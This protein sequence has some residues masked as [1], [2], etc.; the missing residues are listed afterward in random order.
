MPARLLPSYWAAKIGATVTGWLLVAALAGLVALTFYGLRRQVVVQQEVIRE[1]AGQ[2]V[3]DATWRSGKKALDI[4]RAQEE[5]KVE[6]AIASEP[7]WAESDVPESI[8]D[9]MRDPHR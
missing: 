1:V 7:D 2:Q 8:A 3:A 6:E 5:A 4:Y 9:G